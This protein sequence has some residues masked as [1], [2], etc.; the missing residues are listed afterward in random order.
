LRAQGVAANCLIYGDV[1][2]VEVGQAEV[3]AAESVQHLL[4]PVGVE[5]AVEH[6]VVSVQDDEPCL[7]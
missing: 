3:V 2:I 5:D 6:D 1:Q 4:V 7:I